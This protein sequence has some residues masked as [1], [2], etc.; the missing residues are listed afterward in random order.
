MVAGNSD[1][2][3]TVLIQC[4]GEA[5]CEAEGGFCMDFLSGICE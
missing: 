1:P 2:Y 5:G 4:S 3:R